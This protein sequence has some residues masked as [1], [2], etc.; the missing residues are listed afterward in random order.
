MPSERQILA[1]PAVTDDIGPVMAASISGNSSSSS[2]TEPVT[3]PPGSDLE[4]PVS[5]SDAGDAAEL[6][7][8]AMRAALMR[9]A[10]FNPAIKLDAKI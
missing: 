8:A 9:F 5:D 3:T 1:E 2:G 6:A 10:E 4:T 7:I